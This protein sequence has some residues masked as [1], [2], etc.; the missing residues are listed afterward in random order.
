MIER[1][2]EGILVDKWGRPVNAQGYL[3]DAK[4]GSIMTAEGEI[5]ALKGD[6]GMSYE[7]PFNDVRVEPP[8]QA[9]VIHEGD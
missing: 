3:I 4:T 9:V 1:N 6:L 7:G 8:S 5:I 2:N